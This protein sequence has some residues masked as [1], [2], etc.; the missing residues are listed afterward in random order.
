MKTVLIVGNHNSVRRIFEHQGF[1]IIYERNKNV[2]PDLVCFCGGEDISPTLY[3]EKPLQR[4]KPNYNRDKTDIEAYNQWNDVPK[5][6][7]CRG[8]Q[9]LN[10]MSGGSMWQ[11]VDGHCPAGDSHPMIDL[12][13]SRESIPVTSYHH[14]MMIKGPDGYVLA[15]AQE[16]KN[17]ESADPSKQ[18]LKH[19]YDPEVLWY[20]KTKS[21]CFQPHP[22]GEIAK[23]GNVDLRHRH[24]F[25]NLIYWAYGV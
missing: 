24:Y 16:A 4:T 21:L 14:Q 12:L 15:A 19:E 23:N 6:G 10:V 13:F 11:H 17:F 9:L 22:E 20:P 25:F 5:V 18:K 7:I 3:G 1:E 2:R 8:G